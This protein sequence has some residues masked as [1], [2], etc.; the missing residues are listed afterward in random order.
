M[1][2]EKFVERT[3][4]RGNEVRRGRGRDGTTSIIKEKGKSIQREAKESSKQQWR[5]GPCVFN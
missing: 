1:K 2:K 4:R 3:N 5:K